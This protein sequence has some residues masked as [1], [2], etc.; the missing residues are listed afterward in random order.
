MGSLPTLQRFLWPEGALNDASS[1]WLSQS[2]RAALWWTL[3]AFAGLDVAHPLPALAG[4][5]WCTFF[6]LWV[7]PWRL[8][9]CASLPRTRAV[10]WL[11]SLFLFSW[12]IYRTQSAVYKSVSTWWVFKSTPWWTLLSFPMRATLATVVTAT[13]TLIPLRRVVGDRATTVAIAA[14]LPYV[15]LT[16]FPIGFSHRPVWHAGPVASAIEVCSGAL[17]VLMIAEASSLLTRHRIRADR[18]LSYRRLRLFM[19]SLLTGKLNAGVALFAVYGGTLAVAV[20]TERSWAAHNGTPNPSLAALAVYSAALPMTAVA[21]VL[22][23]IVTWRSL[24][25][26]GRRHVAIANL[27]ILGRLFVASTAGIV[28]LVGFFLVMPRIGYSLSE[29]LQ[30]LPGPAWSISPARVP[31]A[32]RLSGEFQYGVSAAL[33]SVLAHDPTIR[34][35]ELNSPGGDTGEGLAMAALVKKYTLSTFVKHD[36]SSACTLV[37]VAGH[38]RLLAPDARLG[39]HRARSYVW[40]QILYEDGWYN[41]QFMRFLIS[42]GIQESFARK[43][44]AIPD[45]DIW[46][47]SVDELLAAGVITSKPTSQTTQR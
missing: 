7:A 29:G 10:S 18:S 3:V 37:F 32:L 16:W 20:W 1:P 13:L 22:A 5:W 26:A 9:F 47:P 45:A 21:V 11:S 19:V 8:P 34:R 24:G 27:G 42:N 44:Y 35:L 33:A 30:L 14:S 36:C 43:A 31:G 6:V 25:R 38:E 40:D 4:E 2:S 41:D 15:V 28:A 39:F 23:A 12:L 46:Y 17:S